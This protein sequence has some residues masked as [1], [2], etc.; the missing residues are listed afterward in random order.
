MLKERVSHLAENK[1]FYCREFWFVLLLQLVLV[2][3]SIAVMFEFVFLMQLGMDL[4]L[5]CC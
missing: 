5:S 2:S 3:I 4:H 1:D